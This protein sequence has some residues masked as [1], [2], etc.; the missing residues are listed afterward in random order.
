MRNYFRKT[1]T[2]SSGPLTVKSLD[3][4]TDFHTT[5]ALLTDTEDK[6]YEIMQQRK[7]RPITLNMLFRN[8]GYLEEFH[9]KTRLS[10][11][12]F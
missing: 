10:Y 3:T 12:T 8:G 9:Y 2:D 11:L 7:T 6:T 4:P 1:K 5:P